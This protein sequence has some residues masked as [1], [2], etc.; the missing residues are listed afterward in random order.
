MITLE[1]ARRRGVCRICERPLVLGSVAIYNFGAEHAH[2]ECLRKGQLVGQNLDPASAPQLSYADAKNLKEIIRLQAEVDRL[3][4]DCHKGHRKLL[5]AN[6]R[7][8]SLI[9]AAQCRIPFCDISS[10]TADD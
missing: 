6:E 3:E 8:A 9:R 4:T 5:A 2:Q 1:E 10:P 7:L